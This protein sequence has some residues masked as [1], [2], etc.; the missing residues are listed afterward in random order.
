M[1]IAYSPCINH[2]IDM[3]KTQSEEKLAVDTGYWMLYRYNPLLAREGKNPLVVDSKE[4]K[5]EYEVFLKNEIRYRSL[6]QQ[7]PDIAK[8]LFAQAAGEAKTRFAIYKKMAE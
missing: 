5:M 4:P 7:Y 1:I 8:V 3:S 6:Q 2:G